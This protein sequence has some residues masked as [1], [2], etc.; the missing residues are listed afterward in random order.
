ML[1]IATRPFCG[2]V[3]EMSIRPA[4]QEHQNK[5]GYIFIHNS[6]KKIEAE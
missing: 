2:K 1:G 4:V 5:V 3:H 6:P